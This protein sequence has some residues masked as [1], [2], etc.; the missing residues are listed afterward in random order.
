MQSQTMYIRITTASPLHIGC[1]EVYEPTSFVIDK[2][3]KELVSFDTARFLEQLDGD[4]LAKFSNICRQGTVVSLLELLRF[5]RDQADLAEGG[6]VA[7]P[8]GFLEHYEQT[9][10]L[11]S[12]DQRRV[13][14]ELN[15]FQIS[16]TAFDP[17]T[18]SA[19]IP[20]S[21]IKGAIRT[22][23]LNFRNGGRK[24]P[25]FRGRSA[26]RELQEH[27]L[28]FKFSQLHSD[29]FRLVKVSD[30]FPAT[31]ERRHIIYAVDRK[32]RPGPRESQAPYQILEAVEP[33]VAFFGTITI[34]H[35]DMDADI[36]KPV[37]GAEIIKALGS[38]YGAEKKREDLELGQ[39]N[40]NP[41]TFPENGDTTFPLRIGR[42]S[43]AECLTVQG[44]RDIRIMQGK[45]NPSKNLDHATTVW[46]AAQEKKPASNRGMAPFGWAVFETL[47]R[48]AGDL[49]RLDTE[50][51]RAAF[52]ES[53]KKRVLARKQREEELRARLEEEKR[54]KAEQA[55]RE[56]A[57]KAII[58]AR[59]EE[60]ERMTEDDRDLACIRNDDAARQFRSNDCEDPI[61]TLW[62]KFNAAAAG[63][64]EALAAAFK[65]RWQQEGR[66]TK[67]ECSK[68]QWEKVQLVK[69]ALGENG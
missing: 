57:E 5:M 22:A 24:D 30:F 18:G 19:C 6:R 44:H 3:R 40:A 31:E 8:D 39:L 23:V 45:G 34:A 48:E 32:K 69:Q 55:A 38:F 35:P 58:E 7:V 36:R 21:A 13:Q 12:G 17:I 4:A 59:K 28:G 46:L 11:S 53:Q 33:G 25:Q 42:H 64:K 50:K 27:L 51:L 60:W 63:H 10:S 68:K 61:N 49:C 29:P 56:E 15:N 41:A 9:L 1:D 37:T 62:P 43:G 20:G 26:G 66:W 14:Q 16:R 54:L 67:K 65:Q 52:L 2:E 47:D